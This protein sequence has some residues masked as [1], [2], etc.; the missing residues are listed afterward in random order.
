MSPA[1]T[2]TYTITVK[3]SGGTV[4]ANATVTVLPPLPT[5]IFSASPETIHPDETSTLSWSS[6]N[7]TSASIDNGIGSVPVNGSI[8]VNPSTTTIYTITLSGSGGTATAVCTVTVQP[9]LPQASLNVSSAHALPGEAIRLYW[10]S[11]NAD[12]CSI[13]NGV[14]A[15]SLNGSTTVS[16][17]QTTTYT[18]SATGPAGT[19]NVSATITVD[20]SLLPEVKIFSSQPMTD[21]WGDPTNKVALI[22]SAEHGETAFLDNGIGS[23][24]LQGSV[25][26]MPVQSTNYT[27]TVSNGNGSVTASVRLGVM[28][29]PYNPKWRSYVPNELD[30]TVSVVN[31]HTLSSIATIP[32]GAGPTCADI[33]PDGTCV[34]IGNNA[35]K[36]I[37]KID[38][39]T[40]TVVKTI[41]LT[42]KPKK[43][44]IHPRLF[45]PLCNLQ[46]DCKWSIDLGGCC[47][48]YKFGKYPW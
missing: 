7:A 24:P 28:V 10:N 1:K 9:Y 25:W 17:A 37:S 47:N 48:R 18:L 35:G 13:D 27:I 31:I 36:T 12:S 3:G 29:D 5:V 42:G 15:V 38:T 44:D 40:N 21:R 45:P 26:V 6:T 20:S 34:F 19:T 14:G 30:N 33:S 22:W 11:E 43:M 16:P 4:S 23:V 32:V 39:A 46:K 2:T 8:A 41:A